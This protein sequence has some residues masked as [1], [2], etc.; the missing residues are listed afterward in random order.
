MA[1]HPGCAGESL[2]SLFRNTDV[3]TCSP[4]VLMQQIR[5]GTLLSGSL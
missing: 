3:S 4:E 1:L 5:G 2:V